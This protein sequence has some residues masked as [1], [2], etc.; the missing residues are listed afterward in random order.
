MTR[1][2]SLV[3][4]APS[5]GFPGLSFSMWEVRPHGTWQNS[6]VCSVGALPNTPLLAIGLGLMILQSSRCPRNGRF[7]D[8]TR[9]LMKARSIHGRS[10][11]Q[12][13][14]FDCRV[15]ARLFRGRSCPARALDQPRDGSCRQVRGL[16]FWR[17]HDRC[18][19]PGAVAWQKAAHDQGQ[20]GQAYL[21]RGH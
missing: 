2:L 17:H 20:F 18:G 10:A 19:L 7:H 1:R 15:H 21:R 14:P 4:R 5:V 9:F 13:V 11:Q 12:A 16:G 8:C 3:T 6:G